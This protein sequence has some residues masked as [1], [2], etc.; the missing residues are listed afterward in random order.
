MN[1]ISKMIGVKFNKYN[2]YLTNMN[3]HSLVVDVDDAGNLK[4]AIRN[5]LFEN[6]Y[7]YVLINYN[8]ALYICERLNSEEYTKRQVGYHPYM[9]LVK[10]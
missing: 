9:D 3:A 5:M 1:I 2:N 6:G 4:P 10:I 8:K 7:D